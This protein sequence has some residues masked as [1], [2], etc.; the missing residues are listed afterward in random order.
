MRWFEWLMWY[1]DASALRASHANKA[2]CISGL[3]YL[4]GNMREK[5]SKLILDKIERYPSV[6]PETFSDLRHLRSLQRKTA[7]EDYERRKAPV[8]GQ[9]SLSRITMLVPFVHSE[10]SVMHKG[11]R[12]Y[13][14][15]D[16]RVNKLV[17]SLQATQNNLSSSR[18]SNLGFIRRINKGITI[19]SVVD[20]S[21]PIE[22]D[23]VSVAL[24]RVT[25]SISYLSFTFHLTS[26]I[27]EK[28]ASFQNRAYLDKVVFKRF[29][30]ISSLGRSYRY[31]LERGASR[32]IDA[33]KDSLRTKLCSWVAKRF[34]WNK[35]FVV[36]S[37]FIDTFTVSGHPIEN[38]ALQVWLKKNHYW[39]QDFGFTW[40]SDCY[41]GNGYMLRSHERYFK[42]ISPLSH[43]VLL[44]ENFDDS[45]FSFKLKA[46]SIISTLL[47]ITRKYKGDVEKFRANSFDLLYSQSERI[48]KNPASIKS[49][50]M[51]GIL[52]KRTLRE[53]DEAEGYLAVYLSELGR[54]EK[55]SGSTVL[56]FKSI[57]FEHI[58]STLKTLSAEVEVV[59]RGVS[60]Y[61][62]LEN[63][64]IMFKLQ[65][66]MFALS[67]IA[68]VATLVGIVANWESIAKIIGIA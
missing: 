17:E 39:L 8:D 44:F 21:L 12:A 18:W 42:Q 47:N 20:E 58:R 9:V 45:L 68:S 66:R 56:D 37:S 25:S 57:S 7:D 64:H 48:L 31:S 52:L 1:A 15:R 46:I 3:Q 10:Y 14:G 11:L 28:Y 49:L 41:Q 26:E 22:I 23:Y 2:F 32:Y 53:I 65:R 67:V 13:Y 27:N 6:G 5:I 63:M 4:V 60:E 24:E 55:T 59:D 62:E 40:D 35:K 19:N 50:K 61:M 43:S 33:Q 34:Q 29:F 36:R 38:E 16:E 30:P 51:H 54:L